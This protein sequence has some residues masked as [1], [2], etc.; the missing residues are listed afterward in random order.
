LFAEQQSLEYSTARSLC[1]ASKYV[2]LCTMCTVLVVDVQVLQKNYEDSTNSSLYCCRSRQRPT[3]T[4]TKTKTKTRKTR[5]AG[6][7]KLDYMAAICLYKVETIALVVDVHVLQKSY[8]DS[9]N[10][11]L[12]C[13]RSRQ[14]P[15]TTTTTTKTRKTRTTRFVKLDYITESFLCKV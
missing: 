12:Y 5:T 6:F 11:S 10:S 2:V 8:E 3:T 9:T 13:C 15:T 14:R 1:T 4:T 7:V